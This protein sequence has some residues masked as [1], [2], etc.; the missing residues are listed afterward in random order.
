MKI[1]KKDSI[2]SRFD[3]LNVLTYSRNLNE[4]SENLGIVFR[5]KS[6]IFLSERMSQEFVDSESS[7]FDYFVRDGHKSGDEHIN[8]KLDSVLPKFSENFSKF[9]SNRIFIFGVLQYYLHLN[10]FTPHQVGF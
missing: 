3:I 6:D 4:Y 1:D 5:K 8:S 2:K 9:S 10:K 7:Q